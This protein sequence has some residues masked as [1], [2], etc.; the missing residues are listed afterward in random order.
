M[1]TNDITP[2]LTINHVIP[3]EK[4]GDMGLRVEWFDMAEDDFKRWNMWFKTAV[5]ESGRHF[6]SGYP[7]HWNVAPQWE[8]IIVIYWFTTVN[9]MVWIDRQPIE[10]IEHY[11]KII[12]DRYEKGGDQ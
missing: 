4:L 2:K 8:L 1:M 10:G 5:P 3:N 6:K 9:G 12:L 11:L 7:K